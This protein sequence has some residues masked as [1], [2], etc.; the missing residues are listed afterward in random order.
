MTIDWVAHLANF[1]IALTTLAMIDKLV[2]T[3]LIC[4]RVAKSDLSATRWFLLHF[5]ANMLVVVTSAVPLYYTLADPYNAVS[6]AKYTNKSFFGAS[7]SWPL[8][9]VN[10]AHVY[11]M[12]GGFS[13]GGADYFHHLL[14]VPLL[15]F[16]GQVLPWGPVQPAGAF[17]ISGLPGGL[18]YLML[19][20]VKLG[21]MN[22]VKEKRVTA[23][24][25]AWVRTPGILITS[26][27]CYQG[28]IYGNHSLPSTLCVVPSVILGPFNALY[29]NKQ[30]VANFAVHYMTQLLSQDSIFK[31]RLEVYS[32]QQSS[33][34]V[35]GKW[36][37]PTSSAILEWKK[38]IKNPQL[39][40]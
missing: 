8:T 33:G 39:G 5:I 1:S 9:V 25:N 30:A 2:L 35:E 11:H 37:S 6:S 22:A 16:P 38:A 28:A 17:F 7:S 31:A 21:L 13:L 15:G 20:L 23:N 34:P 26:F 40:C 27:L 18:T 10:A 36:L 14:F 32:K 4:Y 24:L 19:G 12:L 29:Y 3:P